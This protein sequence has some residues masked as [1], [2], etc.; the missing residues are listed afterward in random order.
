MCGIAV[1]SPFHPQ[2]PPL[3]PEELHCIREAMA[4]RGPDGAGTWLS[5]D[6]SVALAHRRLSILDLSDAGTQPMHSAD[7]RLSIV[8]NGAI[9]NFRAL[10]QHLEARGH[11]FRS[12]SDTEVILALYREKGPALVHDLRGMF[13]FALWDADRQGILLARDPF[14]IKPLYI[15]DDGRTLRFASQVKALLKGGAVDTAPEP[16]GS[17]GFVIWGT[18]PEPY[19]LYPGIRSLP[20]G[21]HLRVTPAGQGA[22][23]RY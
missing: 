2:A 9:Y 22:I 23:T 10:R 21:A 1:I 3:D 15:A 6:H 19:T 18:V 8:F 7:G 4:H 13:A 5:S 11:R 14:G 20:A 17:V 12:T 16:A